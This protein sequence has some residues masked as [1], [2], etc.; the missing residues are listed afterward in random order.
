MIFVK[1][2][3]G[4]L[5]SAILFEILFYSMILSSK[6]SPSGRMF[7]ISRANNML[8]D[9]I[10][11]TPVRSQWPGRK[12]KNKK[13]IHAHQNT[14]SGISTQHNVLLRTEKKKKKKRV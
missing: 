13:K 2:S 11:L 12:G 10:M 7:S 3:D 5:C 4:V 14:P 8:S 9:N 1:I 6:E